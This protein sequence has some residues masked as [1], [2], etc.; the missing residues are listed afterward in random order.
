MDT[1]LSETGLLQA[2]AAGRYLRGITFNNVFVSNLKRAMQV[3]QILFYFYFGSVVWLLRQMPVT[4]TDDKCA[5]T[6]GLPSGYHKQR[7]GDSDGR[8]TAL[9]PPAY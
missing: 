8:I 3:R 9:L 5:I 7:L 1:V 2:E 4:E 6:S